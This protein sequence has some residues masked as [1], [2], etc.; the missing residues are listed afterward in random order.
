MKKIFWILLGFT[1]LQ[2]ACEKENYEGC[3]SAEHFNITG[4]ELNARGTVQQPDGNGSG[5][6]LKDQD[7][8]P[9]N[10]FSLEGFLKA[11]YYAFNTETSLS[12]FPKAL[13]TAPCPPP[14][15]GGSEEELAGLCLISLGKFN[16]DIQPG[17]T[18]QDVYWINNQTPEEYFSLHSQNIREQR[19]LI[20]F[21][22]K[23]D[24]KEYQS[25]KLIYQ[26]TNGETYEAT[27]PRFK[28]Y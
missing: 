20:Y 12:F 13:A 5:T 7:E 28:L 14:G 22:Q 1:A 23:P 27:T 6:V 16:A 21:T 4:L 9:F 3:D 26:L 15:W 17:D 18:L 2:F 25:F 10:S 19:L 11:D 8:V 24:P